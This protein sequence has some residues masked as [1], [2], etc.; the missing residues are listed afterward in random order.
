MYFYLEIISNLGIQSTVFAD[1]TFLD[2]IIKT[3]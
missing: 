2:Q 3:G 1:Q